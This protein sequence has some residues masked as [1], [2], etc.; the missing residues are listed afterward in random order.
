MG[1]MR[2]GYRVVTKQLYEY[3]PFSKP[4]EQRIEVRQ[5]TSQFDLEGIHSFS[6]D[7]KKAELDFEKMRKEK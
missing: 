3:F 2:D 4:G 6:I 7:I 5:A 1:E